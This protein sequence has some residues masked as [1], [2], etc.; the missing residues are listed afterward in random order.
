MRGY[1]YSHRICKYELYICAKEYIKALE[2]IDD[3]YY[4]DENNIIIG[5][6]NTVKGENNRLKG[7][8]HSVEGDGNF[9]LNGWF[10][11]HEI[12]GDNI[13]RI[14]KFDFDMDKVEFIKKDPCLAIKILSRHY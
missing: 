5:N 1:F 10:P 2:Y 7:D 4:S 6:Y 12:E 9:I 8:H 13:V 11:H 14:G 3:K